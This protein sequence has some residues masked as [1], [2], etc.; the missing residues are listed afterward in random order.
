MT[1]K[2]TNNLG[3]LLRSYEALHNWRALAMLAGSFV[4][5]GL[6]ISGGAAAGMSSGSAAVMMLMSLLGG[7]LIVIGMNA[8]GLML[9]DQAYD[10]PIRGFGPAFLGGVQ[11][12]LYLSL[13]HI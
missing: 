4:L 7:I 12:A 11:S 8:S 5:G 13:I 3:V 1:V 9:M 2:T 6:A 10:Q